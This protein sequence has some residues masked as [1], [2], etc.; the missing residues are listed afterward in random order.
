MLFKWTPDFVPNKIFIFGCGGTGSRLVPLVAQFVKSCAWVLDPEIVLVDFDIVEEKNLLR[1]NFIRSDVGKNKAVVLA[2]RYSKAFNI[3]ITPITS[4]ITDVSDK[5]ITEQLALKSFEEITASCSRKNSL[6]I[7]CVDSP[8]ARRDILRVILR[9]TG[10]N[11]NNLLIDAGNENDFGQVVVSSLLSVEYSN[12]VKSIL[13]KFKKNPLN[14][15]IVDLPFLPI[16]F[17]YYETM[18]A[19]STPSCAQL[20]QTMAIN[21]L[22]AVNI[23]AIIQNVYY[24]KPIAYT[25]INVSLQHGAHPEYNTTQTFLNQLEEEVNRQQKRNT[26]IENLRSLGRSGVLLKCLCKGEEMLDDFEQ[27]MKGENIKV[28]EVGESISDSSFILATNNINIPRALIIS[29]TSDF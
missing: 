21:T 12:V 4:K 19:T 7:M 25:R 15:I 22:M 27:K 8:E 5:S 18:K 2:T 28:E 6:F 11:T 9:L 17:T 1:Q 14:P 24:A 3:T 16:D 20:D 26:G 23:F 13:L 10:L 29:T